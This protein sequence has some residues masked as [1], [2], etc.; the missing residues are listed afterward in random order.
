MSSSSRPQRPRPRQ[1]GLLPRRPRHR[2]G[3][4]RFISISRRSLA[5]S[6]RLGIQVA[7]FGQF[8]Y[9][10]H[11]RAPPPT[12]ARSHLPSAKTPALP[13]QVHVGASRFRIP[14]DASLPYGFAPVRSKGEGCG[15]ATSSAPK[16]WLYVTNYAVAREEAGFR[17]PDPRVGG[18][19]RVAMGKVPLFGAFYGG[20]LA[21]LRFDPPTDLVVAKLRRPDRLSL[22][23]S[24][25]WPPR[26]ARPPPTRILGKTTKGREFA[27][28]PLV[29]VTDSTPPVLKIDSPDEGA[30]FNAKV[31]VKGKGDERPGPATLS[32][33]WL[34]DGERTAVELKP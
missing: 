6:E 9:N 29:F 20:D 14:L 30:F 18:D 26:K 12:A 7:G 32:W 11:S 21:S 24:R 16:P 4:S 22:S 33:R 1:R 27:S 10:A 25:S 23:L 28:A 2:S 15:R 17:F 19:G 13:A 8:L 31:S 5:T 34:P 3:S